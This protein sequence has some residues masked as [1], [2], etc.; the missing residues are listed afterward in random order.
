MNDYCL[1]TSIIVKLL[2]KEKGSEA[3]QALFEKITTKKA[4]IIAPVFLKYETYSTLLKKYT[5]KYINKAELL[6]AI[7]LFEEIDIE[8]IENSNDSFENSIEIA[9]KLNQ[10]T[11][12]DCVF[13]EAAISKKA[14]FY[15]ADDRFFKK[16]NKIYRNTT[17]I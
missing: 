13:L 12:Y 9:L 3:A 15:T 2:V 17:L 11:I 8:Y 10:P 14:K 1:D 6:Q 16:A 7:D 4:K 5:F